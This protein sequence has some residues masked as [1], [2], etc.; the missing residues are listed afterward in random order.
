MSEPLHGAIEGVPEPEWKPYGDPHPAEIRECAELPFVPSEKSEKTR[1]LSATWPSA[2]A[3]NNALFEDGSRVRH[4]AVLSNRWE[5]KP[6]R[7]IEWH[8]EKAATIEMVHDVVK[9]EL[10]DVGCCPRSISWPTRR[11]CGWR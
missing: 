7:L 2:F 9:N 6:A 4:F 3:L 8:R 5:L 1:N 10:R 11:G